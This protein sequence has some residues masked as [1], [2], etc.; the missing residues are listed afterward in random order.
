MH[1]ADQIC[2]VMK[3]IYD[4]GLTSLTGGNLSMMDEEGIIWVSPS[5]IDKGKLNREDIVKLLPDGSVEGIH[6]PT[7]EYGIHKKIY[8]VCPG[9]KAVLHAHSPALV[10]LSIAHQSPDTFLTLASLETCDNPGVAEYATPGTMDLAEEVGRVFEA[11]HE[12]VVLKNH[13]AFVGSRI[14]LFDGMKRLEQLEMTSR[15]QLCTGVVG[16]GKRL[17]RGAVHAY[18]E[19]RKKPPEFE[20]A[21]IYSSREREKRRELATFAKRAYDKNLFTG[22][23]GTLSVRVD[24]HTFLI[25]P[26]DKDNAWMS[27]SEFVSIHDKKAEMGKNPDKD[28]RLHEE[29]YRLHPEVQCIMMA[30]PAHITSYAVSGAVYPVEIAPESYGVLRKGYEF[31]FQEFIDVKPLAQ[32]LS[33]SQPFALISNVGA[34][35][36]GPDMT[37]TFDKLEVAESSAWSLHMAAMGGMSIQPLTAGQLLLTDKN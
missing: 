37:L 23:Y 34:I 18:R 6:K 31:S 25:S 2:T 27:E 32:T 12:A 7:S 30:A 17:D 35:V 22:K 28:W 33:L 15:L 36:V 11:G 5:G 16:R 10:S 9:M 29:I 24:S 1:P 13:A 3:Q 21:H 19:S 26:D 14:D 8:D 4:R 20:E